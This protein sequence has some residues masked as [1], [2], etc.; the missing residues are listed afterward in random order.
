MA[1]NLARKEEEEKVK[2]EVKQQKQE[3]KKE[4]AVGASSS[5]ALRRR[6]AGRVFIAPTAGG[7]DGFIQSASVQAV[8]GYNSDFGFSASYFRALRR[9]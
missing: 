7:Q 8:L 2:L 5:A 6:F 1:Q 4:V 3:A 9:G